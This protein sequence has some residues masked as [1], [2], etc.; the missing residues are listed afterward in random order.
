[1]EEFDTYLYETDP[2]LS[3][4]F[5]K[6]NFHDEIEDNETFNNGFTFI[7]PNTTIKISMEKMKDRAKSKIMQ[8]M[9]I[10]GYFPNSTSWRNINNSVD[11]NGNNITPLTARGTTVTLNSKSG[12]SIITF[13]KNIPG[14]C[15]IS[16]YQLSEESELPGIFQEHNNSTHAVNKPSIKKNMRS[17]LA[18]KFLNATGLESFCT[19]Y[20]ASFL[21][22]L[23]TNDQ[24]LLK[25]L[26]PL[27]DYNPI[28][29]FMNVFEIHKKDGYFINTMV[30]ND[31]MNSE[32]D[33]PSKFYYQVLNK[34]KINLQDGLIKEIN[35]VR[36]RLYDTKSTNDKINTLNDIYENLVTNNTIGRYKNVYPEST[37]E[38]LQKA[39]FDGNIKAAQDEMRTVVDNIINGNTSKNIAREICYQAKLIPRIFNENITFSFSTAQVAEVLNQFINTTYFLS[40]RI[41][42]CEFGG[43]AN[44]YSE[45]GP[46]KE[47]VD[48][49]S[50]FYKHNM[51]NIPTDTEHSELDEL[52][53]KIKEYNSKKQQVPFELRKRFI[54][55]TK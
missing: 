55:L 1:M 8:A 6:Y 10:S 20:L 23:N 11:M 38:L 26:V 43:T 32:I 27:L 3:A 25:S 31:W 40:F 28:T 36:A 52:I 49:V 19:R 46:G 35:T 30:I 5:D 42:N 16:I 18:A 13:V 39:E 54:E 33:T 29:N 4:F 12:K 7:L 47:L 53:D 41:V 50:Y 45:S 22:Y 24:N 14:K 51:M 48:P 37:I 17:E 21:Y 15:P 2:K 9:V 34:Y 44:I